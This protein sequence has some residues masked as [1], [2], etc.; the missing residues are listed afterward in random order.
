MYRA[1]APHRDVAMPDAQTSPTLLHCL[2]HWERHAPQAVYLTQPQPDGTVVDY[3]WG[4]V[5][6]QARRMAAHLCAMRLPPKSSIAILG[7]NSAHWIIADLAIWMA[8]HVSVPVHPAA[9]ARSLAYVLQHSETRL[10][11]IGRPVEDAGRW[12]AMEAAV[13]ADLPVIRLPLASAG[14]GRDWAAIVAAMPRLK[15]F[16]LPAPGA[17]ATILYTPGSTGRLRGVMHRFRTMCEV[18]RALSALLDPALRHSPADR[19]LSCLSL[20]HCAERQGVE[21]ASL[22]FGFRVFFCERADTIVQDLRRARPTLFQAL[23]RS[24][25]HFHQA[26]NRRIPP[27]M[28]RLAFSLPGLS[29]IVKWYLLG[30]VGLGEV[31]A[32]FAGS[33]PLSR[34]VLAWYRCLGLNLIIGYGLPENFTYSHFSRPGRQRD[35]FVG[36]CN[37]GVHCRITGNGEILVKSPGQMMG[38]FKASEKTADSYTPD[39]YFKTHDRGDIDRQGRLRLVSRRKTLIPN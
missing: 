26:L 32:A 37:P 15:A 3:R 21:C 19:M 28:Q 18:P 17:L 20:A 7:R 13:P 1:Q 6:D 27:R 36:Q 4:E 9:D 38:Y 34:E 24:W 2:L 16:A 12:Q 14:R 22:C 10:L 11:F 30:R 5:A 39:G 23:P 25:A 29:R 31:R 33:A 35:G 8:G